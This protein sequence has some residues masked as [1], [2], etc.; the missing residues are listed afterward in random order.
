MGDF[1]M[2]IAQVPSTVVTPDDI[3]RM[4]SDM[5]DGDDVAC[6]ELTRRSVDIS[7]VSAD[8]AAPARGVKFVERM[9]VAGL[10]VLNGLTDVSPGLPAE[11]THGVRSVLDLVLVDSQHWQRMGAVQVQHDARVVVESDHE[12][13]TTTVQLPAR[14]AQLWRRGLIRRRR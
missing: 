8:G 4:G 7:G 3:A 1:N 2:H 12:L 13:V 6:R 14:P 11:A 10:V 9:D 5:Q